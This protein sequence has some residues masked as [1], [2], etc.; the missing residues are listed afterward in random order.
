[1][2]STQLLSP[3][4]R[5]V[6]HAVFACLLV[7][8][9]AALR[10]EGERRFATPE[11]AVQA[12][13]T[14]SKAQ[15]TNTLHAIFGPAAHSLASPD[16]VEASNERALFLRRVGAKTEMVR[17]SDTNILLTLGDDG[18][19]FPIPLVKSGGEWFFDTAAGAEEILNRRIGRNELTAIE[20]CR[21][22]V[23]A[24]REYASTDR[25]GDDVLE[26]AQK[27]RSSPGG[28]D[29]LYWPVFEGEELSPFGPLIT[30]A[31]HEGYRRENKIL[32]DNAAP[33]RG[34]YFRVLTR[35]GAHAPGGRYNYIINGHM[36]GGFALIARP[37]EWDRTGVM[38]FI[39][40][41][42]GKVFQKNLGPKTTSVADRIAAY[43]PDDSWTPVAGGR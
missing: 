34:Y 21:A 13:V 20:V 26:Y 1:M 7:L 6:R 38:T 28:R 25:N 37:A 32:T 30:E 5:A 41:Q 12:L 31:R 14:A 36:I 33:Y 35:Q 17:K 43:D 3:A 11:D 18:W 16:L 29:G 24:Q 4:T 23:M 42:S 8:T 10:A 2:N 40:N 22:Y 9:A 15:D 27:L 39:V 19:A